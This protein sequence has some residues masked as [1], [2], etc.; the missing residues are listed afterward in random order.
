MTVQ[1]PS[2]GRYELWMLANVAMGFVGVGGLLFLIPAYVL[3][4]G[5]SPADAG[6]VLAIAS[7]LA[8]TGPL[9]GGAADRFSAH[10]SLQLASMAAIAASAFVL[11][12]AT[13]ELSWGIAAMLLG[14][15]MA[16]LSVINPSMVVG[17]GFSSD[18]QSSKLGSLSMGIPIGQVLGLA[19]I[20]G[21]SSLNAD[22]PT[23]FTTLGAIMVVLMVIVG[24]TNRAAAHRVT[25]APVEANPARITLRAVF[26]S[27]FGLVLLISFLLFG[28]AQMIESQF[29]NYMQDA[30]NIDTSVSAGAL[31]VIV[32]ISIPLY[33][34]SSGIT[35]R[36]GAR[37]GIFVATIM[38]LGSGI[39]LL[40]IT[41]D[42]QWLPLAVVAFI[43]LA[44]PFTDLSFATLAAETS[45]IGVA[46][47]QGAL[48]GVL[49]LGTLTAAAASG[50]MAEALG[51]ASL[52]VGTVI[53]A[54]LT[55]LLAFGLKRHAQ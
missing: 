17:A 28:A 22:F 31:A 9:I 36:F 41:A 52:P 13:E 48:G 45:P 40:L 54:G 49:A 47:G 43:Y 38:R 20:A 4:Q 34:L 42:S 10:R 25:G 5:G 32:A 35:R 46:A 33:A 6:L 26:L 24:A 39:G 37:A 3:S 21:L 7:G 50:G 12:F 55:L 51:F 2:V 1:V 16:G 30:F 23:I 53:A 27:Q 11:P 44:S 29:P 14:L 19:S 8:L 18:E 15:G